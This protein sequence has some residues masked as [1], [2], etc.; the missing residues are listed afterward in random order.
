MKTRL[1]RT[2]SEMKVTL[3]AAHNPY[4]DEVNAF[5]MRS[6]FGTIRA[7]SHLIL[8]IS[9][10]FFVLSFGA[11]FGYYFYK[12]PYIGTAAALISYGYP[13][14]ETGIDPLGNPLDVNKIKAPYV[15]DKALQQLDLYRLG[16]NVE[17]VRTSLT[18]AGVIP[19]NVL[20]QILIIREIATKT[21][22]KLEELPEVQYHPTQYILRL[23]QK[24]NLEALTSQNIVDLLNAV[25]NQYSAHFIEEY[26]DYSLLDTIIE[27]FDQS[28]YDYSEVVQILEGQI[29]NMITYC[30]VI[31]ETSPDFRSS[32]T[33][34][35]FGDIIS[36]LSL[37][38]SV[39]IQRV[40]ALVY[41]SNMSRDRERLSRL[42]DFKIT[43]LRME[44]NIAQKNAEDAMHLAETY[45]K[46]YWVIFNSS[47]NQIAEYAQSSEV[48]DEFFR[49][50]Y[51]QSKRVNVLSEDIGFYLNNLNALRSS[52]NPTNTQDVQFVESSIP[53]IL[54]SL[55]DWVSITNQT[56][57]DYLLNYLYKDATKVVT[58]AKFQGVFSEYNRKMALI[59][60][61]GTLS[62]L[63]IGFFA[64]LWKDT[65]SVNRNQRDAY[66]TYINRVHSKS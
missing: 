55:R 39:D 34:M 11:A 65:F 19:D 45:D 27:N 66:P 42:Y 15:I 1:S 43:R 58:P 50:A 17:D 12:R 57:S 9:M 26:S 49:D 63:F 2:P 32:I 37:I 31:N 53:N 13:G 8:I 18:I 22:S 62:G 51:K 3:E 25:I 60:I 48:Y 6:I 10:I 35:T 4:E 38:K 56:V 64:A 16:I 52:Y 5:T 30:E 20:Q 41:S 24:G 29:D 61:I 36:N 33:S 54:M 47:P 28:K 59:V 44:M 21:P 14:A 7:Y 40:G 23:H 46:D